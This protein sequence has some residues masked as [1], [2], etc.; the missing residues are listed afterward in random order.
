MKKLIAGL[1]AVFFTATSAN[2]AL[3]V[4]YGATDYVSSSSGF[5]ND[6]GLFFEFGID[7]SPSLG[8]AFSTFPSIFGDTL[9]TADTVIEIT[10]G[11]GFDYFVDLV[12]NGTDEQFF[13]GLARNIGGAPA[14]NSVSYG[15]E[16]GVFG[17]MSSA[18]INGI[19]L[20]GFV[21]SSIVLT[22]ENLQA[23]ASDSGFRFMFD[24]RVDVFGD[25]IPSEVP[26]PAAAPL[27]L[28]GLSGIAAMRR[29]RKAA[30]A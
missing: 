11:A 5:S 10:S 1:L 21:I 30:T 28:L 14:V 29:K 23:P 6:G 9:I 19:D 13:I 24:F 3:L 12:T 22:I 15:P 26:L 2:A 17:A 25:A 20:E 4:S 16:S 18:S 27:M 7:P 8:T